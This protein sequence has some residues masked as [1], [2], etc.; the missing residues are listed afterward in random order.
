MTAVVTVRLTAE[1]EW[2]LSDA[3]SPKL[4]RIKGQRENL[5]FVARSGMLSWPEH[6]IQ[7]APSFSTLIFHDQKMKIHDLSAQ[8][9][10][11]SKRYMTYE[12]ISELVVTVPSARDTMLKKIKRFIN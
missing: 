6:T 12:Y 1:Y 2:Y 4:T 3:G 8:H 11:P 10:F 5:M 9:I 7:G